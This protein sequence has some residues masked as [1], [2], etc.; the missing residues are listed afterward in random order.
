MARHAVFP[1]TGLYCFMPFCRPFL[2]SLNRLFFPLRRRKT[3][4]SREGERRQQKD[5]RGTR[6]ARIG[7]SGGGGPRIRSDPG[8]EEGG[9]GISVYT[10]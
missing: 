5:S 6:N 4:D 3:G 1:K 8:S 10:A 7:R 9:S 2:V